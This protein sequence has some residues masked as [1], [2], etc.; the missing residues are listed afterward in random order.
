[1]WPSSGRNGPVAAGTIR[2]PIRLRVSVVL[3][4]VVW[5]GVGDTI[6]RRAVVVGLAAA[7]L[8]LEPELEPEQPARAAT[9]TT[10]AARATVAVT[11][12]WC[13]ELPVLGIFGHLLRRVVGAAAPRQSDGGGDDS[14]DA[15]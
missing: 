4:G 2:A 1:M 15:G 12:R 14:E 9:T 5:L 11:G 6:W 13:R 3:G 10:V 7:E 8:P